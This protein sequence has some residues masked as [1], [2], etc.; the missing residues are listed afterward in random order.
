MPMP[1]P[2]PANLSVSAMITIPWLD[3]I[4]NGP[5]CMQYIYGTNDERHQAL[6]IESELDDDRHLPM[7]CT[8][9]GNG[10]IRGGFFIA[11]KKI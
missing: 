3:M 4:T 9:L 5:M 7:L 1:V 2:M 8:G 6:M 11:C 10:Q